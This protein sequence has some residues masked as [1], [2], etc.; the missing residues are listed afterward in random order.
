MLGQFRI[1]VR[2]LAKAPAFTA[3]AMPVLASGIA[4]AR[5]GSNLEPS[6]S[7]GRP[8]ARIVSTVLAA[9]SLT[10][11]YLPARAAMRLDSVGALLTNNPNRFFIC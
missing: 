1:A 10:A 2:M 4:L 11:C 7:L 9:V 6:A 8:G 5:L 3:M